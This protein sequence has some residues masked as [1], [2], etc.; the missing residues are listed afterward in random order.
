MGG[1]MQITSRSGADLTGE[2]RGASELSGCPLPLLVAMARAE[3]G[4]DPLAERWGT[5]T[6]EARRALEAMAWATLA[7]IIAAAGNDISFG[8]SQRIVR[9]HW[10]GDRSPSI[11][12][13]LA[14]RAAV[15]ADPARDLLEAG[16]WLASHL[17]RA[18]M[19]DLSPVNG[20]AELMALVA[21]NAGHIPAAG[22]AYWQTRAATVER[23]RRALVEAREMSMTLEDR[24]KA[25]EER[26]A[27]LVEALARYGLDDPE[28]KHHARRLAEACSPGIVDQI[29]AELPNP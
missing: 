2:F 8:L 12:N 21:Y 9:Y 11:D 25:E 13:I 17:A 27:Y 7:E 22:A 29:R 20:D 6:G 5:R 26:N 15:F 10:A 19:A 28:A 14:V 3:S 18:R 24:I 16:R 1:I 23:Y 4:L